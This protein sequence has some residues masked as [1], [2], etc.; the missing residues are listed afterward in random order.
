M[1]CIA[2]IFDHRG[3]KFCL[4]P[5]TKLIEATQPRKILKMFVHNSYHDT[6]HTESYAVLGV[7]PMDNNSYF[8]AQPWHSQ[9]GQYTH[10]KLY[11]QQ[12]AATSS[13]Y[14]SDIQLDAEWMSVREQPSS[15]VCKDH[16]YHTQVGE[17]FASSCPTPSSFSSYTSSFAF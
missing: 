2:S 3:H 4:S 1:G 12:R 11:A 5:C 15:Q 9:A 16:S 14:P 6:Y 17:A 8:E 10:S 7:N 13:Y